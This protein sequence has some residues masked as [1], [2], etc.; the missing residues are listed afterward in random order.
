M[1]KW[2]QSLGRS[3]RDNS[4]SKQKSR[5]SMQSPLFSGELSVLPP[6]LTKTEKKQRVRSMLPHVT[7]Q[8]VK[9]KHLAGLS[10][11]S[12]EGVMVPPANQHI[13]ELYVKRVNSITFDANMNPEAADSLNV[14][15]NSNFLTCLKKIG[16]KEAFIGFFP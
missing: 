3:S 2:F 4:A 15:S 13:S 14:K 16:E 12:S 10:R 11:S 5:E 1:K 8:P 6:P 9:G 7:R